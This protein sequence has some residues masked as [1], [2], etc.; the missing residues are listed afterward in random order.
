MGQFF[1]NDDDKAFLQEL[2]SWFKDKRQQNPPMQRLRLDPV[3]GLYLPP[4]TYI[5]KTPGGGIPALSTAGTG[6]IPGGSGELDVPGGPVSCQIYCI[7]P[8]YSGNV[9]RLET[10]DVLTKPVYNLSTTAVAGNAYVTV[11]R[12]KFGRWITLGDGSGGGGGGTATCKLS[13]GAFLA[14]TQTDNSPAYPGGTLTWTNTGGSVWTATN[15]GGASA[16]TDYLVGTAWNNGAGFSI[17]STATITGI[18]EEY[19]ALSTDNVSV[20]DV[21]VKLVVGG[22]IAGTEW[23]TARLITTS[24]TYFSYGGASDTRGLTITP[25]QANDPTLFGMA[26]AFTVLPGATVTVNLEQMTIF[27]TLP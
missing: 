15:G 7:M 6:S 11:S 3:A 9:E 20:H 17:P 27:F 1:L 26:V 22:V 2:R 25:A 24:A 14:N 21:S 19:Q 12:D 4:E 18:L 5:A 16:T 13:Q 23:S 10:V 8:R